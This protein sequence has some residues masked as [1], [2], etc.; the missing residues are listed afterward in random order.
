MICGCIVDLGC[1]LPGDTVSLGINAFCTGD[2]EFEVHYLGTVYRET[3]TFNVNDPLEIANNFNENATAYIKVKVPA[4]CSPP[5]GFN[6]IT[7]ANGACAFQFKS[8]PS[9]CG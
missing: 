1:F 7:T 4:A 2:Y 9:V 8:I 3:L 6:Y 5:E